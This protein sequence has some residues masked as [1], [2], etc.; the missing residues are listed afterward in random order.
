MFKPANKLR[1]I[2]CLSVVL[3]LCGSHAV[4]ASRQV[5]VSS[6]SFSNL[7]AWTLKAGSL[8]SVVQTDPNQPTAPY[9][10]ATANTLIQM[11]MP[12]ELNQ[13]FLLKAKVK[14]MSFQRSLWIGVFNEAG[15]QGYS[16]YWDSAN[17]TNWGGKG[18][19]KVM[20]HSY[21]YEIASPK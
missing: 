19:L 6:D 18:F 2:V 8:P 10:S 12:L 9:I 3:L 17:S 21:T 13:R 4:L 5:A 11:D 14:H 20:R 7:D 1:S 16:L 15:T